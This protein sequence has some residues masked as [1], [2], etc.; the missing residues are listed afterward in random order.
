LLYLI[1]ENKCINVEF[2][3]VRLHTENQRHSLPGSALKVCV[4]GGWVGS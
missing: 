2:V 1:F 4:G 3:M